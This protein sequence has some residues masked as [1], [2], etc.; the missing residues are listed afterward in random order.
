[1]RILGASLQP[2]LKVSQEPYSFHLVINMKHLQLLKQL[3]THY[4]DSGCFFF[5]LS[6]P[7]SSLCTWSTGS[8]VSIKPNKSAAPVHFF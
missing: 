7:Y 1:M 2:V 6:A 8:V 5:Q 3:W 4:L